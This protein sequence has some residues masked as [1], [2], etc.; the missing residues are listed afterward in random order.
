MTQTSDAEHAVILSGGGAYGAYEVG[1]MKAVFNGQ[2]AATGYRPLNAGVFTGTSAGALNAAYM[3]AQPG[4]DSA[5][6]VRELERIWIND[7]SDNPQNCGNGVYRLRGDPFRYFEP[8][9]IALNPVEPLTAAADDAAYFAQYV[10]SRG[11]NFLRSSA[12]FPERA[13]QLFDMSAFISIEPLKQ[14]IRRMLR[15]EC[16]RRSDRLLRVA[17]TNW[18]TGKVKIFG[19]ED[20]TDELG[21]QILQASAATPGIFPPVRI[22]GDT[23]VD[24]GVVMNTP[25]LLAIKA[26][27]TTLHVI[28]LDPDIQSI[29]IR[30]LQNT[31]DTFM[32]MFAVMLATIA[33][34]DID[35]ALEINRGLKLIERAAAGETLSIPELQGLVRFAGWVEGQVRHGLPYKKLTIHRYR[36]HRELGGSLGMLNFDQEVILGFIERGFNDAVN[37]D[38]ECNKC[39]L[40]E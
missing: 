36:P 39:V 17:A 21:P 16:I 29:P 6:T 33:N 32:K 2:S 26:G 20:M 14:T 18:S 8:A 15:F 28:Y 25:L 4:A 35:H 10:F 37:H 24:G 23:Y 30:R 12:G 13:L 34:E 11:L 5:S 31:L 9:C 1:V 7:I 3:T 40:P 22:A 27:A 19:N 38:C